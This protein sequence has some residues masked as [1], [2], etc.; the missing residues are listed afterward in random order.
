M[1]M[2]GE[3]F[4]RLLPR[5]QKTPLQRGYGEGSCILSPEKLAEG[6]MLLSRATI[7]VLGGLSAP[8]LSEKDNGFFYRENQ[9][10]LFQKCKAVGTILINA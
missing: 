4:P 6:S 3:D 5:M 2:H 7:G 10:E 1:R 8:C 9:S